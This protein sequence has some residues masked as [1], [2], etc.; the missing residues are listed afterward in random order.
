MD[1]SIKQYSRG[2]KK[3]LIKANYRGLIDDKDKVPK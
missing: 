1:D 2:I 3:T